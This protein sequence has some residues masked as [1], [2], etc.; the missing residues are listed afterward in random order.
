MCSTALECPLHACKEITF[1]LRSMTVDNTIKSIDGQTAYELAVEVEN[2]E[3]MESYDRFNDEDELMNEESEVRKE[4][5]A[6]RDLMANKYAFRNTCTLYVKPFRT[7]FPMPAWVF[8]RDL[9]YG[10]IPLECKM[11]EAQLKPLIDT[12]YSKIQKSADSIKALTYAIDEA[13]SHVLRRKK[14][15]NVMVSDGLSNLEWLSNMMIGC[16]SACS[17]RSQSFVLN[18]CTGS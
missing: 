13:D 6:L 8:A 9:R 11:H 16:A 15:I 3:F 4:V 2:R 17:Y 14:L 1:I 18:I 5:Q 7:N 12:S 10:S